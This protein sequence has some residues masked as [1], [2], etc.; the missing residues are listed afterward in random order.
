M[1]CFMR[2]TSK[3]QAQH[4][5]ITGPAACQGSQPQRPVR[6]GASLCRVFTGI[7]S[8]CHKNL[9]IFPKGAARMCDCV[10]ATVKCSPAGVQIDCDMEAMKKHCVH[11]YNKDVITKHDGEPLRTYSSLESACR[12]HGLC[13]YSAG[14]P[15]ASILSS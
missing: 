1:F 12:G 2:A 5:R 6:K 15:W 3:K 10:S 13:M 7:K 4:V 11:L 9:K 14:C 8:A